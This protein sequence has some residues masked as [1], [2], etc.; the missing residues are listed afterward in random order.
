MEFITFW[1]HGHARKFLVL[2]KT[3]M[4]DGS[5]MY[6]LQFVEWVY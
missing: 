1:S 6:K 3:K 2:D 5:T 4:E